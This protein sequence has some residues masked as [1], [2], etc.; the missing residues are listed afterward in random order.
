MYLSFTNACENDF[1][2]FILIIKRR[3]NTIVE[4]SENLPGIPGFLMR[5]NYFFVTISRGHY[6]LIFFLLSPI[7]KYEL[8]KRQQ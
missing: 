6:A 5:L 8:L 3:S 7:K 1:T 2:F 4:I